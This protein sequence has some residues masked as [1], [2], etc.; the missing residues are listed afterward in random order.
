[1]A[2]I[3]DAATLSNLTDA[4][5]GT[6]EPPVTSESAAA[7]ATRILDEANPYIRTAQYDHGGRATSM[8]LPEDPDVALRTQCHSALREG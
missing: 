7:A 1:M 3:G 4:K 6:G 8:T 2:V 5:P